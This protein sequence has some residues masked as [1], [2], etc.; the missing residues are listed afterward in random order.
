M[1]E[2]KVEYVPYSTSHNKIIREIDDPEK[3]CRP[4]K[5]EIILKRGLRR[6]LCGFELWRKCGCGSAAAVGCVYFCV[7]V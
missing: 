5:T 4:E 6:D 3:S 2:N 1:N 7:A